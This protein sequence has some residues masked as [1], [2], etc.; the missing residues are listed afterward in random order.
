MCKSWCQIINTSPGLQSALFRPPAATLKESTLIG[1][2]GKICKIGTSTV[3]ILDDPFFSKFISAYNC[4]NGPDQDEGTEKIEDFELSEEL[5]DIDDFEKNIL[6]YNMNDEVFKLGTS[7][8]NMQIAQPPIQALIVNP[9]A[10]ND[11][12]MLAEQPVYGGSLWSAVCYW[13]VLVENPNGLT[14]ADLFRVAKII[15]KRHKKTFRTYYENGDIFFQ[16]FIVD[17]KDVDEYSLQFY[18]EVP[19][20]GATTEQGLVSA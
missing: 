20:E 6:L 15:A 18:I 1:A 14:F 7:Y 3:T 13:G 10:G 11:A 12:C 2:K 5:K 17:S 4:G 19:K 8:R 16:T 9:Y